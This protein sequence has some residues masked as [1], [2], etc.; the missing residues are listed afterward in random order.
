MTCLQFAAHSPDNSFLG[1]VA[2]G[3]QETSKRDKKYKQKKNIA[4]VYAK[5]DNYWI[6][7]ILIIQIVHSAPSLISIP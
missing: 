1:F 4:L 2:D 7:R 6:V 5:Q 3:A